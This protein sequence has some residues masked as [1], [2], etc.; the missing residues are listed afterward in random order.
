[1]STPSA[2]NE[3]TA[4]PSDPTAFTASADAD[5]VS[6]TYS[7]AIGQLATAQQLLS[8]PV[9][10]G[11]P[12]PLGAGSLTL[13]LGTT[14]FTVMLSASNDSLEGIAAAINSASD[15]PGISAT[16]INGT[17]GAHLLLSSTQ[18]GLAN[19]ITVSAD[20]TDGGTGLSALSY[21]SG[22]TTNYSLQ[23]A[24]QDAAFS[25][26]GVPYTSPSNT[27]S[28]ALDGVTLTLLNTT[29]AGSGTGTGTGTGTGDSV[30]IGN[31]TSTVSTNI[32][33]FVT[34]YNTMQSALATLGSYDAS[35]GTAGPM[36]GNP[37][38]TGVQSEIQEALNSVVGTSSYNTLPS[39]GI[40]QNSDGS[41][42]VDTG[43][44]QTALTSNFNAVSQ[45][46]SGSNGVAAQLN[47][48][49]NTELSSDGSITDYGQTLT[50]QNN[51]LA[52]QTT[53][54][55]AQMSA[56]SASLTQQYSSL[57]TLLSSLQSTS[58]YLTQAFA[59]LP[60]VQG[61]PSA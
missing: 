39:V 31:D 1:L 55:D 9:A 33:S 12:A 28:D 16:V 58:S 5:A 48:Q 50:S 60:T 59:G 44:L 34:A 23:S 8:R 51:A 24:A 2:F 25:I 53:A 20:E 14:P 56:L 40:T 21:G 49:I 6:G 41:L 19:T 46:F 29:P 37:I 42:S 27:V 36:M 4:T 18:T 32:Q 17:D 43:T 35:T 52:T 13:T 57:N 3:Q 30:T 11:S 26:A 7:V 38:L 54:L 22:N 47:S 10:A 61:T 15:N 45:L